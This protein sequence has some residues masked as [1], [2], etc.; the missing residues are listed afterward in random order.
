MLGPIGDDLARK[1][2]LKDSVCKLQS[3]ISLV[4]ERAQQTPLPVVCG[5]WY[6]NI[7]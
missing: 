3:V 1:D 6:S 7:E 2:F 4:E 5:A